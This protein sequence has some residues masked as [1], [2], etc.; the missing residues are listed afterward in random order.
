MEN[1]TSTPIPAIN[2]SEQ[3]CKA[4]I[5]W[6]QWY[7]ENQYRPLLHDQ[8]R[9]FSP[10][11]LMEVGMH[12]LMGLN[13][14]EQYGG[15]NLDVRS[16]VQVCQQLGSIDASL[17]TMLA[18][19]NFL[20]IPPIMKYGNPALQEQYLPLL[21]QGRQ[22][23]SFALSE[24]GAGS[25]PMAI[26]G[27]AIVVDDGYL[28]N[29]EKMWIGSAGWSSLIITFAKLVD[30]HSSEKGITC[31]AVPRDK[32]GVQ[33]GKEL[34]TMGMRGMVQNRI[35]FDGVKLEKQYLVGEEEKGM[36]IANEAM[37][38][39][40]MT[41]GATLLGV[42]KKCIQLMYRYA[43]RREVSTGLLLKNPLM[44][45]RLG[46]S[47]MEATLMES[48]VNYIAVTVDT[49]VQKVSTELCLISKVAGSEFLWKAVDNAMQCAGGRG[50]LENNYL[51]QIMRDARVTRIFEG[52]SEALVTHM[53][54]KHIRAVDKDQ[55]Y[56]LVGVLLHQ[57]ELATT[58]ETVYQKSRELLTTNLRDTSLIAFHNGNI[59]TWVLLLAVY[60]GT[61]PKPDPAVVSYARQQ[62]DTLI[63]QLDN[64]KSVFRD[65]GIDT[66]SSY[67]EKI[68][69]DIGNLDILTPNEE[70]DL[71][72]YFKK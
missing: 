4:I 58:L 1:P 38:L 45:Q 35:S 11:V 29:A 7:A 18:N 69:H 59:L 6:L 32:S 13:V 43:S 2:T 24:P 34:L 9:C 49:D 41:A 31:F 15:L 56:A 39:A 26:N 33:M 61:T 52:P 46:S 27:K 51:P 44:R 20:G 30:S 63:G 64:F 23:A 14:P 40:R 68:N 71:D 62:I 19:H 36:D 12:G 10:D 60:A 25:N 3:K 50:Y 47:M 16:T 17:A 53:G 5:E 54:T 66:I 55:L 70:Y 67:A 42:M 57:P 72:D 22:M 28:L 48:L 21:A 37:M 65:Y 8:R